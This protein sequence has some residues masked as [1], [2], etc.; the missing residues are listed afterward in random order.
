M[1]EAT[2]LEVEVKRETDQAL[3]VVVVDTGDEVWVPKSLICDTSEVRDAS[4][5]S[6]L[7][8]LPTWWVKQRGIV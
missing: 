3:L 8:T 4:E 2:E 5:R 7:L 1:S 6:G